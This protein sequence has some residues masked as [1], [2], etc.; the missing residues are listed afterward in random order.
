M[1][2]RNPFSPRRRDEGGMTLMELMIAG[3]VA[4]IVLLALITM[5]ITSMQ[6]WDR[7]GARLA[8]QRNAALALDT[9]MFDVRH[10]S[11]V[12][13]DAGLTQLTIYRTTAAGDSTIA[14]Y[15][16]V[17][18]ELRNQHGVA[19]VD[20]VTSLTFTSPNGV[21][22]AVEMSLVDDLG[23]SAVDADDA[24]IFVESAAVCRNLSVY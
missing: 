23:T 2:V 12:E 11:R 15:Q 6:A 3:V 14:V 7:A 16:L 22:V 10:G 13:V 24:T 17:G 5:Y 20:R 8:L 21:K 19:L 18:D 1:A 4:A 9:V